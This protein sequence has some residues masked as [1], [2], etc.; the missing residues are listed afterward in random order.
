MTK[1]QIEEQLINMFFH[2]QTLEEEGEIE[3][4]YFNG[5]KDVRPFEGYLCT[6]DNGV[7]VDLEDDTQICLTIQTR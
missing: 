7:I 6:V 1:K 2:Q 3:E 4:V 5:I